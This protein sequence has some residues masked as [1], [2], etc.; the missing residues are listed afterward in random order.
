MSVI[1]TD[2]WYEDM[3]QLVNQ[4][5]EFIKRAPKNKILAAFEVM[6]DEQSPYVK[7]GTAVHYLIHMEAGQ[8]AEYK[9]LPGRHDGNGLSFRFTAPATVWE[10]IAAGVQDPIQAGLRGTIKVRGDM[11]FLMQH[12]EAVKMLVD[13]YGKQVNTEWPQG[14]PPYK[15]QAKGNEAA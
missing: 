15:V 10:L 3:K 2:Q 5:E 6:G 8:V 12:A 7:A 4:T 9:P 14:K 13:M 11:R 1:Y